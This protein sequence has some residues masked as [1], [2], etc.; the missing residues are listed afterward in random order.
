MTRATSQNPPTPVCRPCPGSTPRR[1][2]TRTWS[3]RR[4]SR[5]RPSLSKL[6]LFLKRSVT[7]WQRVDIYNIF[8]GTP[9]GIEQGKRLW[10]EPRAKT[11]RGWNC[12][13]E[14]FTVRKRPENW[15]VG[16]NY[17]GQKRECLHTGEWCQIFHHDQILKTKSSLY[18]L[19]SDICKK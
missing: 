15:T 8:S 13:N 1:L 7:E 12:K 9:G 5:S 3:V 16:E 2:S 19:S 14:V 10:A 17:Q 11:V 18:P 6:K 4:S